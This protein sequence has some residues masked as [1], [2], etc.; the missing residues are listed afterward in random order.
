MAPKSLS[1]VSCIPAGVGP[2]A[3]FLEKSTEGCA[4][5]SRGGLHVTVG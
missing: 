3:G 5:A 4:S 2:Q 1:E